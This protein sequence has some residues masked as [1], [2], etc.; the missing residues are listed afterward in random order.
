MRLSLSSFSGS[1]RTLMLAGGLLLAGLGLKAAPVGAQTPEQRAATLRTAQ[2]AMA[3]FAW[4]EGE[5]EGP[6]TAINGGRS[7][8]L[9]QRETVQRVAMN[10]ALM[11]Q[12]RGSMK[13]APDQPERLVFNAAGMFA[14]DGITSRYTFFSA[15]GSGQAQQFTA[16]LTG[17]DGFIWGFAGA[18][19]HRTRYTIT[20]TPA[21]EWHEIGHTSTDDGKTWTRTFEMTLKRKP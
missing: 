7:F 16:E 9:T 17:A 18:D 14:Y 13:M 12:G 6:A 20:R 11:I 15:S 21:G 8:T 2:D 1:G 10:T 5:W 4:L 19:G 3:R